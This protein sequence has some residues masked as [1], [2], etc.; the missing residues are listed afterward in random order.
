VRGTGRGVPA[1]ERILSRCEVAEGCW[2]YRG[3]VSPLG[4][5]RVYADGR[6]QF[7][8]RLTWEFFFGEWPDGLTYDHLCHNTSCVNPWHGEPVPMAVNIRRGGNAAKTH[9]PQ[10]H[11]YEGDNVRIDG[12]RYAR[13]CRTCQRE[14]GAAHYL[15]KKETP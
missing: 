5:A 2:I 10:G 15:R 7:A 13:L 6:R 4:Y 8:H 3:P 9:C 1:I 12:R 14:H 11:P